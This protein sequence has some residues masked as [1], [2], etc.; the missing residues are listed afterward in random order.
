MWFME[1]VVCV[2]MGVIYEDVGKFEVEF[3]RAFDSFFSA[4]VFESVLFIDEVFF[5]V[6]VFVNDELFFCVY[7]EK[8]LVFVCL[9]WFEVYEEED[10]EA[11]GDS[12]F[13][14]FFVGVELTR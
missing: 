8:N 3:D 7:V 9:D 2:I 11:D 5:L 14:E 4:G 13:V 1:I 10:V 12:T 6:F